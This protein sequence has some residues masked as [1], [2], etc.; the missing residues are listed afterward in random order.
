M[1]FTVWILNLLF[2]FE[3]TY[4]ISRELENDA[5]LPYKSFMCRQTY[6][7]LYLPRDICANILQIELF[8]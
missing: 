6:D 8:E 2:K 1:F 5:I 3:R 4:K 7:D